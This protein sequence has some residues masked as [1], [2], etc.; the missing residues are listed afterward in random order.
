VYNLQLLLHNFLIFGVGRASPILNVAR[1]IQALGHRVFCKHGGRVVLG[2]DMWLSHSVS[3]L[4]VWVFLERN[5][6]A[7]DPCSQLAVCLQSF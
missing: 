3:D 7:A 1:D 4:R 5:D 2:D 6:F